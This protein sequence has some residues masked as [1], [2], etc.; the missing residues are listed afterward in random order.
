MMQVIFL[1]SSLFVAEG[2]DSFLPFYM[3]KLEPHVETDLLHLK[4]N[5]F[6]LGTDVIILFCMDSED[7]K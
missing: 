1:S 7:T 3:E 2:Y 6:A 4:V 5:T